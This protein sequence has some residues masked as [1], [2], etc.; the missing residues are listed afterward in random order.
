MSEKL[1]DRS[2]VSAG[3]FYKWIELERE[4]KKSED[5]IKRS[6]KNVY[7]AVESES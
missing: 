2:A 5:D 4:L 1:I 3:W 7:L 6:A